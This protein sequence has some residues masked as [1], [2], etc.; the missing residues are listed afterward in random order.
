ML[1]WAGIS[2][3][4]MKILF[5]PIQIYNSMLREYK[6][7]VKV[8]FNGSFFSIMISF[9]M[10]SFLIFS[11]IPDTYTDICEGVVSSSV[12]YFYIPD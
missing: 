6:V 11:H 2:Y 9:K 7:S 4:S 12:P 10:P 5:V 1:L 3:I 8:F